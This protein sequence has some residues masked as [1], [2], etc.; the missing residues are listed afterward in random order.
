M[1][2][3]NRG[4][5]VIGHRGWPARFP[6]NSLEGIKAAAEVAA[7]VE[8][9]V[10]RH[11]LGTLVLS[12]DPV[13]GE[14]HAPTLDEVLAAVPLPLNLEIKNSPGDHGFEED[15]RLALE[16]AARSR[17]GD[18]LTC[19]FW[20][21]VDEVRLRHP[22][23]ATGLLIDVGAS[24]GDATVHALHQGHGTLVPNWELALSQPEETRRAVA[25]GLS[26]AVWTVNDPTIL[27]ALAKLGVGAIIT[28]H[29]DLMAAALA[30][31][32]TT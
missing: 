12:H 7:M 30:E 13:T 15:H 32:I 25:A 1:T 26:V 22:R 21:T 24:L 23:V 27:P 19:F 18:L 9:D 17:P 8:V 28:D 29:P 6:D 2:S 16:T 11:P 4:M 14:S 3:R 20:P 10:R 5:V 31:R